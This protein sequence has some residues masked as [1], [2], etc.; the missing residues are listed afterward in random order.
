MKHYVLAGFLAAMLML[1]GSTA[2]ADPRGDS[3][4]SQYETVTVTIPIGAYEINRVDDGYDISVEGFGRLLV[5]GKPNLPSRIF[6][7]AIP[8]GATMVGLNFETGDGVSL[9]G[10][11][12]VRPVVLPRVIGSEDPLLYQRDRETYER[13][14]ESVY[15]SDDMYPQEAVEFV[16]ASGYRQYNMVDVRISPF[17]YRP[18]S[19]QLIYYPEISVDV[20]YTIPDKSSYNDASAFSQ[21][22]TER[23]AENIIVKYDQAGNWYP[24]STID[25]GLHDYVIITLESLVASVAPL[26]AWETTKGRTVEIVTTSWIS[27]NYSG[28]DLAEQM[29]NFLRDKYP[30]DEWG[31]QD[32]LLVGH[33]DDVPMRRCAQDLGYGRPETDFYYAELSLPDSMSWDSDQDRN[34]G[35]NSDY[36][37]FAAEVQV[38]RIPW[39]DPST[40]LSICEKSVAYEQNNNP[41]FKKNILLLG[42]YFWNDDP[43]PETDNA[44]L[45]EAK[46]DQPWMSDWTL[47]RMYE[48][49]EDCWSNYPCDFPLLNSNVMSAWTT[50]QYAFVNW[51]GHGSPTS[52]HVYGLGAPAFISSSD[53]SQLNDNYPAIIFADACSN[54][55]TDYLNIGQA[56]IRQGAIAF[57]GAT[58]VA[59][60]CPG[61]TNP[62][63]G[64]SQSLDY[65]FTT[66]VTSGDYTVGEAHQWALRE[67]YTRGL[68]SDF[69]YETFEWGALWGNPNLGMGFSGMTISLPEGTPEQVLPGSSIT[70]LVQISSGLDV[71]VSG[72]GMVHYRYDGGEYQTLPLSELGNDLFEAVLPPPMCGDTPQFYFSAE[73][74]SAG[75]IFEPANAPVTTY[76]AVVGELIALFY[77]DFES[78]QGWTVENDPGLTDGAWERGVPV[79]GGERG[80]PPTDYDGSGACYLTDNE[81]G[82]SD[83]DGGATTLISPILDLA[84]QLVQVRYARWYSNNYGGSP[85]ADVMEVR[86]SSNGGTDWLPV[87]TVGP[88]AQAGGGWF[89]YSFLVND[90]IEPSSQVRFLFEVSDVGE[91]SVVE[92]GLDDFT[93]NILQCQEPYLCGDAD[94]SDEVDI[95][96]VVYLIQY[97]FAQGPAPEPLES[98]DADCSGE[99]DIDDVVY[100]ITYI[101]SSGPAPCDPDGDEIPDC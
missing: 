41:A 56:M 52:T 89:E 50:G 55:D 17:A 14:Y 47:T 85:N 93:V 97:I 72:S 86:I 75:T 46:V 67:M 10:F 26:V 25:R 8:P 19:G 91:G 3:E 44:V 35:E 76:S 39:S 23:I 60:G 6:S 79:G 36:I 42:A 78:D 95:D 82:D 81:A 98:G 66:C 15:E 57:V 100:L 77:D 69:R 21:G 62:N 51:A 83:V 5:P 84:G 13:N 1:L 65:F 64:S 68:W 90:L 37:D 9:A 58:K 30:T 59:Y 12:D 28:Y 32:V 87:E 43:N 11:Y 33:Y 48:Q 92:A 53:C 71:Y 22:R 63:D 40:V 45:M 7:I 4:A 29:R 38:G 73:A 18:Q 27:S 2:S 20:T 74:E 16:G 96:D 31:I 70:I 54:S 24:R 88:V 99:V 61:W 94:G 34:W 49:N 101:F 80:D